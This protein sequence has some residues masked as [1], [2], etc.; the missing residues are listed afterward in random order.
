MC[1][2]TVRVTAVLYV[3][4]RL[5][6]SIIG[7]CAIRQSHKCQFTIA[8][9][10]IIE[11]SIRMST[12]VLERTLSDVVCENIRIEAARRGY[13]QSALARAISMSQPALNQ[14]WRG[15]ARWQLDDLD[16]LIQLGFPIG[17]DIFGAAI[18]EEYTREG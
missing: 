12:T 7:L 17:L 3:D 8:S 6:Y 16:R 2:F 11:Y 14:R 10:P 9:V 1:R 5:V 15:A 18:S 4:M 13:S